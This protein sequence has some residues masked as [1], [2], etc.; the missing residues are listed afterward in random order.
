MLQQEQ[1]AGPEH[2]PIRRFGGAPI[3]FEA[4]E[5]LGAIRPRLGCEVPLH[6]S[7]DVLPVPRIQAVATPD[8]M[9]DVEDEEVRR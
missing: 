2:I 3:G 9:F 6:A 1:Q 4:V 8:E 5:P 7:D